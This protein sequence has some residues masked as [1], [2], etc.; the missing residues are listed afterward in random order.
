MAYWSGVMSFVCQVW[1]GT[2]RAF[3]GSVLLIIIGF[4]VL[5]MSLIAFHRGLG[6]YEGIAAT[7]G[8][9]KVEYYLPYPGVLPDSPWY[10]FKALRDRFVLWV[11]F[12]N[13]KKAD[14]ELLYANKRIGAAKYLVEGGKTSLGVSTATKAEK[15]L[16]SAFSRLEK[17]SKDGKDVKSQLLEIEKATA[18][19]QE[20]LEEILVKVSGVEKSVAEDMLELNKLLGQKI[21]QIWMEV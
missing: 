21:R 8:A 19:H 11:M 3:L 15:Y 12:D 6:A 16:E 5:T 18:K 9:T 2:R 14:Q 10:N 7:G 1:G 20:I 4:G 13:L 17:L